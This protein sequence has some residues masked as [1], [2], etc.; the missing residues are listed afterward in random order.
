MD[1]WNPSLYHPEWHTSFSVPQARI[2]SFISEIVTDVLFKKQAVGLILPDN[3]WTRPKDAFALVALI[4]FSY[5]IIIQTWEKIFQDAWINFKIP[6]LIFYKNNIQVGDLHIS[7][8]MWPCYVVDTKSIYI[9]P[10]HFENFQKNVYPNFEDFSICYIMAHEIAHHVQESFFKKITVKYENDSIKYERNLDSITGLRVFSI[11]HHHESTHQASQV[12]ELHADYLAGVAL[13]HANKNR[14]FIHENDIKEA[15]I[16]ALL[17]GD[18]MQQFRQTWK[19]TP[20]NFTH[21]RCDQRVQAFALW[22]LHW[23]IH[24]FSLE[25]IAQLFFKH[26]VDQPADESVT[27][28]T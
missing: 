3:G 23:D 15:F 13:H 11:L 20:H 2:R 5:D 24:R 27:L 12:I 8:A 14:P 22:L 16:T 1:W 6:E 7:G 9:D 28:F 18:D 21:G 19:V 17:I 26:W 25:D 4:R 10:S